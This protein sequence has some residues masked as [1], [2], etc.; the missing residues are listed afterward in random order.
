MDRL[1][2]LLVWG[3]YMLLIV[4]LY[5]P[6]LFIWLFT[7]LFDKRLWLLHKY[8]CFWASMVY[9][10][11]PYWKL[12][13]EGQDKIDKKGVYIFVS[14]HQSSL[15]IIMLHRTSLHFK[16]VSKAE[17]FRLPFI[18]WNMWA[19]RYISIKRGDRRSTLQMMDDSVKT[20]QQGS[21]LMIFPEGTRSDDPE[22]LRRFRE[23]AFKLAKMTETAIV[24]V[25][26]NGAGQALPP[27]GFIFKGKHRIQIRFLD[28]VPVEQIIQTEASEMMN[29][30]REIMG[31]ELHDMRK[32]AGINK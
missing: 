13:I 9:W 5:P 8:T 25:M 23:G 3:F 6:A 26:I 12:I 30:L 7:V 31:K 22:K 27:Y 18:G 28:P 15:D 20:I 24:P 14:N 21:S 32:P 19:N 16:W 11:N 1:R 4:A 2:S 10:T 29:R 17:L